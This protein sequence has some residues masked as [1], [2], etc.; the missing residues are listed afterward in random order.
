LY[1]GSTCTFTC[2]VS[3]IRDTDN[4]DYDNEIRTCLHV[5]NIGKA[6]VQYSGDPDYGL[7]ATEGFV[8]LAIRPI[9]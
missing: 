7:P 2:Y 8:S 3:S 4:D 9:F 5:T 1:L 6:G